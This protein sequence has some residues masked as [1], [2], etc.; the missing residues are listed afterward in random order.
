MNGKDN[1]AGYS[2]TVGTADMVITGSVDQYDPIIGNLT[3][4]DD[5][6]YK[7]QFFD[8]GFGSDYETGTGVWNE[9]LATISRAVVKTS[10]ND[11]DLVDFPAGQKVVFL[12]DDY[13]S[14]QSMGTKYE[15]STAK[16]MTDVER[17]TIANLGNSSSLDVGTVAGTVA[18]G[19]DGRFGSVDY[20][21][22]DPAAALDGTEIVAVDQG[23]DGVQTTVQ[24][25]AG[26]PL[27]AMR[28]HALDSA[29]GYSSFSNTRYNMSITTDNTLCDNETWYVMT[30]AA[31]G[32]GVSQ[33]A[34]VGAQAFI[35]STGTTTTGR[36]AI[37]STQYLNLFDPTL[38]MDVRFK[39][40]TSAL[41]SVEAYTI[42]IGFLEGLPAL[43][44]G[45]MYFQLSAASANWRAIVRD[46]GVETSSNLD[47]GVV[48]AVD[49]APANQKVFRV[50]YD[51]DPAVLA[52]KFYINGSLVATIANSTR[53]LD[54]GTNLQMAISIIKS[55][56]TTAAGFAVSQNTY[57]IETAPLE[58]Y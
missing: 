32:A 42:Q 56:G 51:S 11:G 39:G 22:L 21:D 43:A 44:T 10:S 14:I 30:D 45:G 37:V 31:A 33:F 6:N 38:S 8:N 50:F 57:D 53:V 35:I 28:G 13:D 15:T 19:D 25:I 41:P 27:I 48:G 7:I 12:V 47:T 40:G 54:T 23:G 29:R 4:G 20:G 16:I 3:D 26:D 58:L 9:G 5:V 18:A 36:A 2:L 49:N 46:D 52:T 34:W 17:T 55:A 24:D 1:I